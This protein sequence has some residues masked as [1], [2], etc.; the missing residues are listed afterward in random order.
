MVTVMVTVTA[1]LLD[2]QERMK[3]SLVRNQ[4]L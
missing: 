3:T 4:H 2:A 1:G